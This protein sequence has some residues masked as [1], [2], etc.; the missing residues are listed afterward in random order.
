MQETVITT[1]LLLRDSFPL[2]PSPCKVGGAGCE[3]GGVCTAAL[4]VPGPPA[5]PPVLVHASRDVNAPL[6]PFTEMIL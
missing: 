1:L 4:T 5:H 3:G 6:L 2:T